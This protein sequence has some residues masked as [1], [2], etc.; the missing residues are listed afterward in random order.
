MANEPGRRVGK[1]SRYAFYHSLEECADAEYFRAL[2][3]IAA[4]EIERAVYVDWDAVF[5]KEAVK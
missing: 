4:D 5:P 1:A 2:A 3:R